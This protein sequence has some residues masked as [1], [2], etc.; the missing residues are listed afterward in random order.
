MA[1]DRL[2]LATLFSAATGAQAALD[3][4]LRQER[5]DV[6]PSGVAT[7]TRN[8][9]RDATISDD[10]RWV[11]FSSTASDLVAGDTNGR[12]DVFVRDRLAGTTRLLSL[13]ANGS[14]IQFDAVAASASRDGRF[15]AFS[16]LDSGIVAGDTNSAVDRFLIDRDSDQDDV[17]DEPGATT[18]ERISLNDAGAQMF[19]GADIARAAVSDDGASVAFATLQPIDAGDNNGVRD[20][21]VRDRAGLRTRL[22]SRATAGAVGNAESPDFFRPAIAMSADGARIAFSST[23]TNLCAQDG[24]ASVDVFLRDRDSDGN[25]VLD[26]A[27]GTATTC[28]SRAAD[29]PRLALGPFAQFDLDRGGRWFA[30]AASDVGGTNPIGADIWLRDIAQPQIVKLPF[31][32]ATWAKGGACCGNGIPLVGGRGDVVAFSSSQNY[33]FAAV[34]TGRSDVFVQAR[35]RELTRLTDFPAPSAIDDGWSAGALALAS[36]G[37]RLLIAFNGAGATALPVE[38]AYVYWRDTLFNDGF[39]PR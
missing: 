22:A 17:F 16:T 7:A 3:P 8:A 10:G 31:V 24:D 35:G 19:N 26:E 39:E 32:A 23:A 1:I 25:G 30:I 4:W 27:G 18:V 9:I 15:V 34:T 5:I 2:V 20:V 21:H 28:L 12:S 36:N 11:V 14:P 6:T 33:V 37:S 29:G 13:R 38:G